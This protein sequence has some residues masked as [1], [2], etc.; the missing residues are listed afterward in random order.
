M[1]PAFPFHPHKPDCKKSNRKPAKAE[2]EIGRAFLEQLIEIFGIEN[3]IAVG[4]CAQLTL[5][6]MRLESVYIRHPANGG[7]KKFRD[8]LLSLMK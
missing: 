8:G 5:K 1:F 7:S 6:N 2:L 4:K 3:T